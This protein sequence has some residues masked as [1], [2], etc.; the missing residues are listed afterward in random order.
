[1]SEEAGK[2]C[3]PG[4]PVTEV[5]PCGRRFAAVLEAETDFGPIV[6]DARKGRNISQEGLEHM[7]GLSHA[8]VTK[9]ENG[10]KSWGK[11]GLRMTNTGWWIL[12]AL[13]LR[14]MI[15]DE[16]TAAKAIALIKED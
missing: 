9:I 15:V 12:E 2:T 14:L 7:V 8:H 5:S 1:M 10:D 6:R 4:G 16:R 3:A 13:G 11:H